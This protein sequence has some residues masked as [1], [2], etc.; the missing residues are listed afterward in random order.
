[1][2]CFPETLSHYNKDPSQTFTTR[3]FAALRELLGV[4]FQGGPPG[5][6]CLRPPGRP[7]PPP[8]PP[9]GGPSKAKETNSITPLLFLSPQYR[10]APQRAPIGHFLTP[11]SILPLDRRFSS[12]LECF[13]RVPY[14]K[15]SSLIAMVSDELPYVTWTYP[16]ITNLDKEI[17]PG[18]NTLG[19]RCPRT[20]LYPGTG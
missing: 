14:F 12:I 13:F 2:D 11:F 4:K 15:G 18:N 19:G 10:I 3:R 8:S 20:P 17:E 9:P 7:K 5:L 6:T 1:V 16:E